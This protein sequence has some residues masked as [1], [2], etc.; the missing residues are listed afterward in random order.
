[1]KH[2]VINGRRWFQKSYGNTYCTAD[3][4]IDGELIHTLPK[5][6]G[7]G[8]YYLQAASEWLADNGHV[9]LEKHA[10]GSR[11]PLWQ[12]LDNGEITLVT[13]VN[14]VNRERDL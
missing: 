6:Y 4:F 13:S 2:I 11:E 1:M 14:D 5:E 12:L 7:Y 9:N 10:N 3:I 8:D